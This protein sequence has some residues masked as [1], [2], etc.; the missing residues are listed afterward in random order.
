[1]WGNGDEFERDN[2]NEPIFQFLLGPEA[3]MWSLM[4][5]FDALVEEGEKQADEINDC[6]DIGMQ[7]LNHPE[8]CARFMDL[9][10]HSQF[11]V[12]ATICVA[13]SEQPIDTMLQEGH[14]VHEGKDH[15]LK[16]CDAMFNTQML[17]KIAAN[18]NEAE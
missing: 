14:C 17:R 12:A 6:I 9:N 8:M 1:M 5:V 2:T 3:G 16:A 7:V 13:L 11:L 15:M 10:Y 18:E 4:S